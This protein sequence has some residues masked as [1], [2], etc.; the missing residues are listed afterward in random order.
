M[1]EQL[2]NRLKNDFS[3]FTCTVGDTNLCMRT[4][5]RGKTTGIK[6]IAVYLEGKAPLTGEAISKREVARFS[7]TKTQEEFPTSSLHGKYTLRFAAFGNDG[8]CLEEN[9]REPYYVYVENSSTCPYVEYSIAHV[10]GWLQL[11]IKSNCWR[12]CSGHIWAD[13]D[14]R[15]YQLNTYD[16]EKKQINF[17]FPDETMELSLFVD[18]KDIKVS[19]PKSLK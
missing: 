8:Q 1:D 10:R 16:K 19:G 13:A 3:D 6:E 17:F 4:A 2:K 5:W 9:F 12:R 14:G 11:S 15:L 7:I 18:D